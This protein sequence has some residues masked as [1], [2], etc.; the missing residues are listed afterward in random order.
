MIQGLD[1][2]ITHI[3]E[4]QEINYLDMALLKYDTVEDLME[5]LELSWED[6]YS[7]MQKKGH[8]KMLLNFTY[9]WNTLFNLIVSEYSFDIQAKYRASY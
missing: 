4:Q 9:Y 6:V 5:F 7:L 3:P 2:Y 8:Q 1:S